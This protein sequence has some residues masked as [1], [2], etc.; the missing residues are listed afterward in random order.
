M[1]DTITVLMQM[2]H[3]PHDTAVWLPQ[4]PPHGGYHSSSVTSDLLSQHAVPGEY[5]TAGPRHGGSR[6]KS[7]KQFSGSTD[8]GVSLSS[9]HKDHIEL[10]KTVKQSLI[11]SGISNDILCA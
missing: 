7:T 1:F 6:R 4:N 10:T 9:A 11:I 3:R 8:S 2:T 5:W